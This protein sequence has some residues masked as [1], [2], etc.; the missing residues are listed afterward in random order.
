MEETTQSQTKRSSL[1]L[2]AAEVEAGGQALLCVP[3]FRSSTLGASH[4]EGRLLLP[5]AQQTL[6]NL[7]RQPPLRLPLPDGPEGNM[8]L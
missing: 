4:Q 7:T 6:S 2:V 3:D 1:S 5:L 8:L